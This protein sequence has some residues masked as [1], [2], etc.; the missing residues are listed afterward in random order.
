M[1]SRTANDLFWM[2][3]HVERA[4]NAARMLDITY[5][6]S[7]LPYRILDQGEKWAEP[8]SLPLVYTGLATGYYERHQELTAE[9]VL[10]P[11][12]MTSRRHMEKAHRDAIFTHCLPVRRNVEVADE[13]LDNPSCKVVDEAENRFH[14]QRAVLD[15]IF[16][17]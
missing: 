15:W 17:E 3:R 11:E 13:V 10:Q 2:S 4:E 1:L 8:W 12:W 7:L 5:R 16:N 9:A 14:V 6:M